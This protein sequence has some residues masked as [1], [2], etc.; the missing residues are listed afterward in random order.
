MRNTQ[1]SLLF[2]LLG[3]QI[4]WRKSPLSSCLFFL[5]GKQVSGLCQSCH[6]VL[7][8][9]NLFGWHGLLAREKFASEWIMSGVSLIFNFDET[10]N[11]GVFI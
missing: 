2:S 10:R 3:S 7:K 4:T 11:L 6:W 8:M 1:D 5:F 9:C